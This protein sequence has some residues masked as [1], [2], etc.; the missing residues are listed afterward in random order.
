M[1]HEFEEEDDIVNISNDF[2][3]DSKYLPFWKGF[4]FIGEAVPQL[5]LSIMLR[6]CGSGEVERGEERVKGREPRVESREPR[7]DSRG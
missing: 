1:R 7:A 2:P 3:I 6:P 4:E 5:I